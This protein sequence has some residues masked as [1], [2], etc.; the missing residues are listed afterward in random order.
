MITIYRNQTTNQTHGL[1]IAE[2]GSETFTCFTLERRWNENR[3]ETSCY[4]PEPGQ[5]GS[6][7][8]KIINQKTGFPIIQLSDTGR[9]DRR[10]QVFSESPIWLGKEMIWSTSHQRYEFTDFRQTIQEFAKFIPTEGEIRFEWLEPIEQPNTPVIPGTTFFYDEK[11]R[12][13]PPGSGPN[14]ADLRDVKHL[15]GD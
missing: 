6:V 9:M 10:I 2:N 11:E 12:Y 15:L 7:S 4:I 5:K 3:K 8:Y 13:F 1:L 14:Q